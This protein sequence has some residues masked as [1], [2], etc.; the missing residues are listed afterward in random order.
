VLCRLHNF[1]KK[2][3]YCGLQDTPNLTL[4]GAWLWTPLG[5]LRALP[6]P[7]AGGK[8]DY[9]CPLV[10]RSISI[11][12]RLQCI[13]VDLLVTEIDLLVLIATNACYQ[14]LL[15]VSNNKKNEN[16]RLRFVSN[17][18]YFGCILLFLPPSNAA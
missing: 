9:S 6:R 12:L 13:F 2:H 11:V 3:C 18:F 10:V 5:E 15:F 4:A 8:G 16:S 7:L 14:L 1:D 17:P